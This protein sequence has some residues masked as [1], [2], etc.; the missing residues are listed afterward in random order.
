MN[1]SG[2]RKARCSSDGEEAEGGR[3]SAGSG[4]VS[5]SPVGTGG[6]SDKGLMG[7]TLSVSEVELV[8]AGVALVSVASV[9]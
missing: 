9:A 1:S 4:S 8:S 3:T 6:G 7:N 2:V 5:D